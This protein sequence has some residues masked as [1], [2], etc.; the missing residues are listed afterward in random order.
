MID[1]E[2]LVKY[3]NENNHE[4]SSVHRYKNCA[5][6]IKLKSGSAVF[7]YDKGGLFCQGSEAEKVREL[8]E[9]HSGF[10]DSN[11][12]VFVAY[13]HDLSAKNEINDILTNW[14]LTPLFLDSLPSEGRT[15][16]EQLMA[17]I[18]RANYG[19]VLM[20]PDDL[21]HPVD[22]PNYNRFRARQNVILELGMLL[23]KLGRSR[24]AI[25]SKRCSGGIENPS[26]IDGVL[27]IEYENELQEISPQ[28]ARELRSQGYSIA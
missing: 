14:D 3:L 16:I 13:G 5:Y 1:R 17:Y 15:I 2:L 26:D 9:L 21:A 7:L 24:V 10:E 18:P 27:R 4:V 8:I 12:K 28:L 19:V 11:T 25:V 22:D 6:R 20:T 23:M